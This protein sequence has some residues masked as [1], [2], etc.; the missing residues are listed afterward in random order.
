MNACDTLAGW[1]D[2][3]WHELMLD[4]REYKCHCERL[5]SD[6]IHHNPD[7]AEDHDRRER[8]A[9]TLRLY[10]Q[11]F[12]VEPPGDL[13]WEPVEEANRVMKGQR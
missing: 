11:R 8:Y 10:R 3:A 2:Q 12:G 4:T 9:N 5:G 6:F 13:I 7:G 1:V